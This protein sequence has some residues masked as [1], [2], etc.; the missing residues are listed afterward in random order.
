[1]LVVGDIFAQLKSGTHKQAAELVTTAN[2]NRGI[3][4][5]SWAAG[6][7]A[8]CFLIYVFKIEQGLGWCFWGLV[9]V[10]T[11]GSRYISKDKVM[12]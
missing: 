6:R 1:M 11:L 4:A 9:I 8:Q 12:N 5:P 10:R 2:T 7:L 3:F